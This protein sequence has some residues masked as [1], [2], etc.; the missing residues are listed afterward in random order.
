MNA[1]TTKAKPKFIKSIATPF[2]IP[3]AFNKKQIRAKI[4][5]TTCK[6]KCIQTSFIHKKPLLILLAYQ[7]HA[8]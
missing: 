6:E 2:G 5:N 8:V 1:A 4:R 7:L 3:N